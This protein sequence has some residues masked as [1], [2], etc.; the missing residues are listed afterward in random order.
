MA[1]INNKKV[2]PEERRKIDINL[3]DETK[4]FTERID[5]VRSLVEENLRYTKLLKQSA[6]QSEVA[7]QKELQK[8]LQENLKVSKELHEMTKKIKRWVTMQRVW[9]V[10]KILIILIPIILGVIY[11]PPLLQKVL[12]PYQELLNI[13]QGVNNLDSQNLIEKITNQ[14]NQQ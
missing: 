14:I 3:S 2:Y 8:L 13:N 4:S 6:P 9:G 5:E 1:K 12:E 7:T 10:V 11:L